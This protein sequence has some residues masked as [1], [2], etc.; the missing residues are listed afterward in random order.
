MARI[1]DGT[2]RDWK[3]KDIVNAADYKQE[4]E[5]LR[6][7][8]NDNDERLKTIENQGL[9]GRVSS[10][11]TDKTDKTG[12]HLGTWRGLTPGETSEAINGGRLDVIEPIIDG[13]PTTYAKK[14]QENW[15]KATLLNGYSHFD[16]IDS[17][18]TGLYYMIDEF[19]FVHIRGAVRGTS[20]TINTTMFVLPSAYRP[21]QILINDA[22]GINS[23]GSA[24]L[25][26]VDVLPDGSVVFK[27]GACTDFLSLNLTPFKALSFSI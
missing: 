12:D 13:L 20:A 1:P 14:T 15:I 19:G 5:V 9:N 26:R 23:G 4:R 2:L 6:T 22:Y 11:E 7:A 21:S 17:T 25:T 18:Y 8:T 27:T 10:L 16:S 24:T 3:D